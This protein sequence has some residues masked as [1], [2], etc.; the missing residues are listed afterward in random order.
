MYPLASVVVCTTTH[1]P[2]CP[3]SAVLN[4]TFP[5][6]CAFCLHATAAVFG[7]TSFTIL[8]LQLSLTIST[9]LQ[10]GQ[11][12][13][14]LF[15]VIVLLAPE[16][17]KTKLK[18]HF[19]KTMYLSPLLRAGSTPSTSGLS[20]GWRFHSSPRESVSVAAGLALRKHFL[21]SN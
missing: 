3:T 4:P 12:F 1:K 16:E 17:H 11:L 21:I 20:S 10:L 15:W 5:G 13:L 19:C 7:S 18:R 9:A 6:L 14:P 2:L 8:N